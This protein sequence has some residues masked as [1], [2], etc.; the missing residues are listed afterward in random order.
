MKK[1]ITTLCAA[2]VLC[3]SLTGCFAKPEETY[4]EYVQAVLDCTYLGTADKYMELTD[5]TAEEAADIYNDQK[6]YVTELICAYY[7]VETD[8][9]PDAVYASY[10]KLAADIM[11]KVKYTIE[12]AVKAGEVYHVTVVAEPID[13]WDISY[14]AIEAE[15][16]DNFVDRY[17]S[18]ETDA[19]YEALEAEWGD[20]VYRILSEYVPQIGYKTSQ[21]IIT[22]IVEDDDTYGLSDKSWLDIDDLLLDIAANT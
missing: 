5:S 17:A 2:S 22:E 1:T 9:I 8:Y 10:E 4:T 3:A 13:L 7:E 14:D 21:S 18:Y 19:E 11:S 12:P 15:F 16:M 6:E 20:A